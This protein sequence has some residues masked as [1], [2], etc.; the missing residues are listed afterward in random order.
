VRSPTSDSHAS[1]LKNL[2]VRHL[3]GKQDKR[4]LMN[5]STPYV[6]NIACR[7][8]LG[9]RNDKDSTS[10]GHTQS[11]Y[12]FSVDNC[13]GDCKVRSS[14]HTDFTHDLITDMH[15]LYSITAK[16]LFTPYLINREATC[17]CQGKTTILSFF[18]QDALNIFL[19]N[20]HSGMRR[21]LA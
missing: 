5:N 2:A 3:T 18:L 13:S 1:R 10:F 12:L 4:T 9:D 7:Y 16:F 14:C 8:G 11:T 21:N 6:G 19:G 15:S 20:L 17:L